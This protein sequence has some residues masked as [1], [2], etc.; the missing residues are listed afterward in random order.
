MQVKT[1]KQHYAIA[2]TQEV[3][4][5][6]QLKE[7]LKAAWLIE[8]AGGEGLLFSNHILEE[9]LDE[10]YRHGRSI[11][12]E[13]HER[14]QTKSSGERKKL[15]LD[16]QLAQ[17]PKFLI[18]DNPFDA[19]DT[20]KIKWFKEQLEAL[21]DTTLLIQVYRREEDV[22]PYCTQGLQYQEGHFKK[23]ALP[24]Q[25][26]AVDHTLAVHPI[27]EPLT[28][29]KD[30]PEELIVL[31]NVSVSFG[32]KPVLDSISWTVKRG[33]SWHLKG[34]NGSGKTTLLSMI[35]GDS[36]KGYGKELYLFG[37]KKGTGESVWE[38]KQKIGYFTTTMTERF[39]GMHD[40]KNMI[41]SG[42]YDSVGLYQKPTTLEIATA[43]AWLK[44]IGLTTYSTKP[45]RSL[46]EVQKRLVLIARAM[47]KHPPLLI[48]DEP[49]AA[50]DSAGAR[51]IVSLIN[52]IK[53]GSK[54]AVIYVS[55]REEPGL[56]FKNTILFQPSKTGSKAVLS[57]KD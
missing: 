38:I 10:E 45:F 17:Q 21:K 18:L 55:H 4:T 9:Y 13:E 44:V 37:R 16:Y 46:T 27:P 52:K 41:I 23:T 34:P 36:T 24:R 51:L 14:L 48:L 3:L 20:E 43:E 32:E 57:R 31:K 1:T 11:L 12:T 25:D 8:E 30:I 33:T 49:T 40:V 2:V 39:D 15:L 19:L 35:T 54:T 29:F 6:K 56:N 7:L 26:Q 53:A 5:K 50:L 47:I 42:L 22:L 28:F